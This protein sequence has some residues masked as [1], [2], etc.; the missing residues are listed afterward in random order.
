MLNED[1]RYRAIWCGWCEEETRV[2]VEKPEYCAHCGKRKVKLTR[3]QRHVRDAI[4]DIQNEVGAIATAGGH[5]PVVLINPEELARIEELIAAEAWPQG[6]D[7]N[8][9]RGDQLVT[10]IVGEGVA[11][12]LLLEDA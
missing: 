1:L 9:L 3:R 7:G 6:W 2:S 8:E 12:A 11:Q 10:Q 5:P 4:L